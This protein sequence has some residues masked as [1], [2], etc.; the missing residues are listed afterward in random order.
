MEDGAYKID[1]KGKKKWMSR[2]EEKKG[3]VWKRRKEGR[4]EWNNERTTE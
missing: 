4:K 3:F 1:K 2:K